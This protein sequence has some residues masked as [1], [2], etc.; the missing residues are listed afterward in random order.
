MREDPLDVSGRQWLRHFDHAVVHV[1]LRTGD[2]ELAVQAGRV[3]TLEEHRLI[4]KDVCRRTVEVV[5]MEEIGVE[6]TRRPGR[7][8]DDL[9]PPMAS[10]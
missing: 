3:I 7:R 6:E 2:G 5:V 10:A 1:E 4:R 9:A 8:H